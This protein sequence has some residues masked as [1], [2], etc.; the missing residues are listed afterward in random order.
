MHLPPPKKKSQLSDCQFMEAHWLNNHVAVI[1]VYIVEFLCPSVKEAI[2]GF[3][4]EQWHITVIFL[5]QLN[6]SLWLSKIF[7][8]MLDISFSKYDLKRRDYLSDCVRFSKW[9]IRKWHPRWWQPSHFFSVNFGSWKWWRY[10]MYV[11]ILAEGR[12]RMFI[13]IRTDVTCQYHSDVLYHFRSKSCILKNVFN[14]CVIVVTSVIIFVRWFVVL[15]YCIILIKTSH[16]TVIC[17]LPDQVKDDDG[18]LM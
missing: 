17:W 1:T 18:L 4:T 16:F 3:L 10:L 15:H 5:F 12:L 11:F 9:I 8:S 6:F 7:L 13:N 2:F 14:V